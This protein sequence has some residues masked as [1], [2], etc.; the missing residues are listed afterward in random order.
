[1]SSDRW[2]DRP[3]TQT[4]RGRPERRRM[5]HLLA[6]GTVTLLLAAPVAAPAA[7][8]DR[9]PAHTSVQFSIRH[10]MV[11][12]VRGE[13]AKVSGTA[14]GDEKDP[15]HAKIPATIDAATINTRIETRDNH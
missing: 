11:S 13:F 12:N 7:T 5:R 8:W 3:P 6:R 14:E 2:E 15:T 9:D 4:A 1:M 10:L